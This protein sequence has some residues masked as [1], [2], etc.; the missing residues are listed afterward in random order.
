M[1]SILPYFQYFRK[2][3]YY[4]ANKI[5]IINIEWGI[6]YWCDFS[7]ELKAFPTSSALTISISINIL[8]HLHHNLQ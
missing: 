6:L 2:S 5:N 1:L 3:F 7:D 8:Y 4:S